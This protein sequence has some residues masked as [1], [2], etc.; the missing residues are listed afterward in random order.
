MG[1]GHSHA[2]SHQL[3]R[4]RRRALWTALG[5]NAACLVVEVAAGLAF[6]SLALLADA[7]HMGSDVAALGIALVAHRLVDERG[8][9]LDFSGRSVTVRLS[10]MTRDG[11]GQVITRT[12]E[13]TISFR[14]EGD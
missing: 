8:F 5:A 10:L 9:S 3:A 4:L 2:P 12:A 7:A 13:R 6:G 1:D 14:N 11:R